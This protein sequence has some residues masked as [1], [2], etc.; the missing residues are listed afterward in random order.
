VAQA[1]L[2]TGWGKRVAQHASGKSSHNLF[3]IKADHRW[4]GEDVTISTLE[5]RSGI[6]QR[7]RASFRAYDTFQASFNDYVSIAGATTNSTY[8][9]IIRPAGTKG[10]ASWQGHDGTPNNGVSF[11]STTDASVFELKENY[12]QIQDIIAKLTNNSSVYRGVFYIDGNSG[13][14]IG[15]MAVDSTNIGAGANRGFQNG[16]GTN[17]GF[18][19]CLSHNNDYVGIGLYAFASGNVNFAYNCTVTDSGLNG[20]NLYAAAGG[21]LKVINSISRGALSGRMFTPTADRACLPLSPKISNRR[22]ETALRTF[23]C[24]VK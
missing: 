6:P 3:N 13:L 20:F 9:R 23:G 17:L 4:D 11:F 19:D 5:F 22:S 24:S 7:E 2:E 1:A 21:I 12:S 15:S 8:F 16:P 18:V 14:I 10:T